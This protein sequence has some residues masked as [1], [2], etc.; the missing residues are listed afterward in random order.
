MNRN[1][2]VQLFA[3]LVM[4]GGL[5][6]SGILTLAL[7][8]SVG[9]NQLVY[10]T[11]AE[12]SMTREEALGIAAGAFRG[13]FVNL[14]WI[15]ANELKA[16]GKYWEAVDL[17]RTITRLQP[18]FPRVWSF[19]AWNLAY[20]IS[21]TTQTPEE[22]WQWVNAGIRLLRD[23]GIPANPNDMLL[24]K[25]LAWIF[26]HKVQ[27]RMDDA[28]NKYKEWFAREWTI[29]VGPP[30]DTTMLSSNRQANIEAC[31]ARL[32]NIIDAPETM[33]DMAA[34]F[35]ES[36][37]LAQRIKAET[38]IDLQTEKGR[39]E[40]LTAREEFR[41]AQKREQV[42]GREFIAGNMNPKLRPLLNDDTLWVKA[43]NPLL[44]HL[45]KRTI[46][47]TYKMEPDRMLRYTRKYGPM[48]W[49]H[50]ASHAVYWAARGVEQG[51]NRVQEQNQSDFDFINT[52]RMV[53]HAVQELF[54][55]GQME[56]DI[57]LPQY[58]V[59]LPSID[60]I[61][62]YDSIEDELA[63]R[64]ETQM[65][66]KG[67]DIKARAYRFY[68]EGYENF[69]DDAVVMLYRRHENER[70]KAYQMKIARFEG[71]NRNN[72]D[73]ERIRNLPL[74]DFVNE[75]LKDRVSTPNVALQE[76]VAS[77]WTAYLYGLAGGDQETFDLNY[78]YAAKVHNLFYKE[79]YRLTNVDRQ[80]P[81]MAAFS[82]EFPAFAGQMLYMTTQRGDVRNGPI[83]YA[84]APEAARR[85]CYAMFDDLTRGEDGKHI[86]SPLDK[87]YPPPVG[88][89]EWRAQREAAAKKNIEQQGNQQLK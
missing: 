72:I 17:A 26:L 54:R 59:Q 80:D 74:A 69:L 42:L 62:S 12:G 58:M 52:D 47:D 14:L 73:R 23:E 81:R 45:R 32:Q 41:S 21:V 34:N 57:L 8:G 79:Q 78:R 40:M 50:P 56:Y 33:D 16:D 51:L 65:A 20:N 5:A 83:I 63:K 88:Y 46:V 11:R 53:L 75:T 39:L 70:A 38:G 84:R 55:T 31:A 22:R 85:F 4:L 43:W 10:T 66:A 30:P 71:R 89:A 77:L 37:A 13:M 25:E 67:V 18:R 76:I 82:V 3:L 15:R 24:H 64:E 68:S 6:G 61:E 35:P 2:I 36:Y 60:F 9:R 49:R 87:V 7:S 27:M 19:H 86:D 44:G 29:A 48:D 28:N 1:G